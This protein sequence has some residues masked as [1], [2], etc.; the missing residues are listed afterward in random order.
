[1]DRLFEVC[2][3]GKDLCACPSSI[4]QIARLAG[5]ACVPPPISLPAVLLLTAVTTSSSNPSE[6]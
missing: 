6:I 3:S 2:Q 1:M 5:R 4:G